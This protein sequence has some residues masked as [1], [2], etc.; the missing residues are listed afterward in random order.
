MY[1]KQTIESINMAKETSYKNNINQ[2]NITPDDLGKILVEAVNNRDIKAVKDILARHI[3]VEIEGIYTEPALLISAQNGYDEIVESILSSK[4][5]N[6][7]K[8]TYFEEAFISAVRNNLR[9]IQLTYG[10]LLSIEP[11]KEA[12]YIASNSNNIAVLDYLLNV[13]LMTPIDW[14]MPIYNTI[15]S[16][17][18]AAF[19]LM[20]NTIC[21]SP[22]KLKDNFAQADVILHRIASLT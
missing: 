9:I 16:N 7:I 14:R 21:R 13:T 12:L 1:I 2:P 22:S 6:N 15:R 4:L 18:V 5:V 11:L 20:M 8:P 10:R 3:S 19:S 17:N